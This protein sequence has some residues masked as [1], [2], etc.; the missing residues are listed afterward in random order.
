MLEQVNVK[1][2]MALLAEAEKRGV[3]KVI[4]VSS[5]GVIG[6]KPDNAPE[7]EYPDVARYSTTQEP[8]LQK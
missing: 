3:K 8:L 5:S 4:Y 2:T 1:G 6:H 7:R